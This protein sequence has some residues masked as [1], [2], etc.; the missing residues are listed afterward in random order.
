MRA[1]TSAV[2][3]PFRLDDGTPQRVLVVD[4]HEFMHR[5]IRL[6]LKAESIE[7]LSAWN[8]AEAIESA[9]RDRP[10]LILLDIDL[11][12]GSGLAVIRNLKD[13]ERT[14]DIPIICM[15][16]SEDLPDRA[17]W[18]HVGEMDF[19]RK[20]FETGE[21]LARVR[22]GMRL[23]R[24]L[25]LLQ[26][27]ARLDG[28]TGLWNREYFESR[29]ASEWSEASRHGLP[30]SLVLGDLDGFK[31]INDRFGHPFGDRVLERFA[32]II[33]GGRGSDVACRYGGEE[34][35]IL[36]PN[37]AAA[38]ATDVAERW[39]EAIARESFPPRLEFR[40]TASFGVADLA[41]VDGG[42]P[43]A[44][45]E[46]ADRALYEAKRLGRDRVRVA[47]EVEPARRRGA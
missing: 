23:G 47:F 46:A 1:V 11:P 32:R 14:R 12:D 35:A 34:F 22:G 15:S 24:A 3:P 2:D 28:L 30:L 4:D 45:V 41:A 25:R 33:A 31:Q 7:V 10:D 9:R 19:L 39:R 20:P 21:L 8:C 44:L 27:K 5:L 6:R 36:L 37:T 40:A 26:T 38:E 29:L 43:S 13:G 17:G 18:H 42:D 16:A